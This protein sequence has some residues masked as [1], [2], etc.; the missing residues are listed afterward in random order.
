MLYIPQIQAV[1]IMTFAGGFY[2]YSLKFDSNNKPTYATASSNIDYLN[3]DICGSCDVYC[4]GCGATAPI[5]PRSL[6]AVYV[7]EETTYLYAAGLYPTECF[8]GGNLRN[9][10]SPIVI[11]K[12]NGSDPSLRITPRG[13]IQNTYLTY[14]IVP[15]PTGIYFAAGGAGVFYIPY[16]GQ[17]ASH[18][19]LGSATPTIYQ[20]YGVP[21]SDDTEDPPLAQ[22]TVT[23]IAYSANPNNVVVYVEPGTAGKIGRAFQGGALFI[24]Y[25][26]FC[27]SYT[28]QSVTGCSPN[29]SY[30]ANGCVS[31]ISTRDTCTGQD[32]LFVNN[33]VL[34]PVYTSIV[35]VNMNLFV[36]NGQGGL[37]IFSLAY[38]PGFASDLEWI[39]NTYY[40]NTCSCTPPKSLL[41]EILAGVA[42]VLAIVAIPELLPE[43]AGAVVAYAG[44]AAA[45]AGVAVT[46]APIAN[47]GRLLLPS[48]SE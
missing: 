3:T 41:V 34:G 27:D 33:N 7:N 40:Q 48:S 1:V 9:Q 20:A 19:M 16:Q 46:F 22:V 31:S 18:G 15:A 29:Q 47:G 25:V 37:S 43:A 12:I 17:G 13:Y 42:L 4:N 11:F 26:A 2:S 39:K 44:I 32:S 23:S 38:T 5:L 8:P 30:L 10:G 35:D 21:N 24:S 6:A 45:T 14:Q 28:E 36:Q